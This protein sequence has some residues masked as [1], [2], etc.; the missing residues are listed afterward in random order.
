[1][2]FSSL[3]EADVIAYYQSP[4]IDANS[5]RAAQ[6]S[7]NLGFTKRLFSERGRLRLYVSDVFNTARGKDVTVDNGTTISSEKTHTY[8]W[9][10]I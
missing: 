8:R 5:D 4:Y 6:F 1:M 10:F 7:V 3:W 2:P 9:D